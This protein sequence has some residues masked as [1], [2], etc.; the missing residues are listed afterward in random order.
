MATLNS[1]AD[2]ASL[3]LAATVFQ[4]GL[5]TDATAA[6]IGWSKVPLRELH[7]LLPEMRAV[8]V[9]DFFLTRERRATFRPAPGTT[10]LRPASTTATPGL[11]LAGAYTATG[12]PATMEGAVRSGEAAALFTVSGDSNTPTWRHIGVGG[13]S[14]RGAAS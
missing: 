13:A 8:Q 7:A 11:F 10:A 5:F 6:D 2:G 12:W 4:E 9:R 14:K 1:R 3:S